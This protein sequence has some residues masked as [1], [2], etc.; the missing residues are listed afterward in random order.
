MTQTGQAKSDKILTVFHLNIQCLRNKVEVFDAFLADK[1]YDIVCLTEHWLTYDEVDFVNFT[2]YK[3]VSFFCRTSHIHG[4]V[5]ILARRSVGCVGMDWVAGLSVEFTCE[6]CSISIPDMNAVVIA[7]YRTGT[8]DLG[9]FQD[10]TGEVLERILHN[11]TVTVVLV[12]DFNI[13]F[14]EPGSV[15]LDFVNFLGTFG[16]RRTVFEPTRLKNCIDNAF[17]NADNFDSTVLKP[18]LS[19]HYAVHVSFHLSNVR[20]ECSSYIKLRSITDSGLFKLYNIIE[21]VDWSFLDY[22]VSVS[23]KSELFLDTLVDAVN[24]CFPEKYV[25][26]TPGRDLLGQWFNKDLFNMRETLRFMREALVRENSPELRQI[27]G[28]YQAGYKSKVN[29]A[30]RRAHDAVLNRAVNFSAGAWKIVNSYRGRC[31]KQ[32]GENLDAHTIND[33]F[34]HIADR[35]IRHIPPSVHESSYYLSKTSDFVGEFTIREVSPVEIRNAIFSMKNS[36][37]YDMFF[38]NTKILKCIGNLIYLPLCRLINMCIRRGVFPDVLKTARVIPV[39]KHGPTDDPDNFRPISLLPLI[40]K[41]FEKVVKGQIDTY[42]CENN[43]LNKSQFGFRKGLSTASAINDLTDYIHSSFEDKSM[44]GT[45]FCDLSKAF[46]CVS[47]GLLLKKLGHYGF[48]THSVNLIA[49][50]LN[51]RRQ[52]VS[53]RGVSSDTVLITCGVP[54]GSILGPI[55]FL[56]YINDLAYCLPSDVRSTLYADDTTLA[57]QEN[58][59]KDLCDRLCGVRSKVGDWFASNQLSLN[60]AKS[61]TVVFTL[62][63]VYNVNHTV[64]FLGVMLDSKLNWNTHI[65]YT[66]SKVAK[67]IYLLRNIKPL[68]SEV[69]ALMAYRSLVESYLRYAVLSWGHA[70]AA[71]RLFGFQRRAVRV[72]AG[73]GYRDDCRSCFV[74]FKLMTLPSIYILECLKYV[75]M[76][77]DNFS[78]RSMVHDH[79]TRYAGDLVVPCHRLSATRSGIRFLGPWLF[80]LLPS[81][82]RNLPVGEFT[83]RI[84]DYLLTEAFFSVQE[85]IDGDFAGI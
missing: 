11:L 25:A 72:V 60:A 62:S 28:R 61:E 1:N 54:Q 18:F 37:S 4:G 31:K 35:I 42:L 13:H 57:V 17:T 43:I 32:V 5:L 55:L 52:F 36:S 29:E 76:N 53:L 40:G 12:W 44:T 26:V 51:G 58:S 81:S 46:D 27:V 74:Q 7:T 39:H 30:K 23:I 65:D 66:S 10:I 82:I 48:S 67:N 24:L 3:V 20:T 68:V 75:K 34:S 85:C 71:K 9:S 84:A 64:K 38:M 70:P 19:D 78:T 16:L 49:S 77:E 79:C 63:K 45:I 47:H 6:L 33:Y 22:D 83:R 14:N 15:A 56:I 8:G 80:N 50:Y 73:I 41:V 21:S 2:N 59:F 69:V